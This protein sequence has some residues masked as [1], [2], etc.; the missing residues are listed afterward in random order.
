MSKSTKLHIRGDIGDYLKVFACVAVIGQPIIALIIGEQPR[1]VQTNLGSIYNL[2]KYTAPAFIFGILYT[3]IRQHSELG[4][5]DYRAYYRNIANALFL[6]TIIW[7]LIY[8]LI[9]PDLQQHTHWENIGTFCWQFINGNAAPHLWYNTMMLQFAILVPLFWQLHRWL[10]QNK[11]RGWIIFWGTACIYLIWLGI[12]HCYIF[13]QPG[14]QHWYL[15]D[16]LF[17]SFL[18]YAVYGVLAWNYRRRFNHL[19]FRFW[20]LLLIGLAITFVQTNHELRQFGWP[21]NLTNASYYKPSMTIYSLMVI[22]LIATLSLSNQFHH[23][24]LIQRFFHQFADLAYQA[25]LSN[26]FWEQ[27]IWRGLHLNLIV[28][29][30]PYLIL[31]HLWIATVILSFGSASIIRQIVIKLKIKRG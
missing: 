30:H 23:R 24:L 21:V 14:G 17:I 28:K 31:F 4:Y 15:V 7:S 20:P 26:V 16:R 6:P 19:I 11:R 1:H 9:M 12:Y 2:I 13:H 27:L 8:L 10:G 22:C 29:A 25:Y 5:F 18:I 3:D